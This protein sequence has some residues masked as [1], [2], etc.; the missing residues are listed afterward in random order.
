MDIGAISNPNVFRLTS[1]ISSPNQSARLRLPVEPTVA[2]Y[3][4]L[5]HISGVPSPTEN[6]GFPLHKL[7][8]LD[9]LIDRL[10]SLRK[11]GSA[12]V[13]VKSL[14]SMS[15]PDLDA[16]IVRLQRSV[17]EAVSGATA[18]FGPGSPSSDLALS[19]DIVA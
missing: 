4:R 19:L 12:A 17:H 14:G 9:S 2:L 11:A 10:V 1:V 13:S 8:A 5:K 18:P 15:G 3:A 16:A 7:R 6:G